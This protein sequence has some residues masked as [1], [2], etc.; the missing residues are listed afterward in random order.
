MK[1]LIGHTGLV[2]SVLA[3]GINTDL[4]YNSAN[5][6]QIEHGK[7]DTVYCAAPSG[8]R[9]LAN[10]D[11]AWDTE[12]IQRLVRSLRT[13]TANRFVLISS[14]DAVYTPESA[15]GSNR[16]A[17][18]HFAQTQFELC[19]VIRLCTLIHPRITKNLLYDIKHYQ[20]LDRVNGAMIRQY[21][22]LS[23][24]C[25]DIGRV[26]QH[27]I[28]TVNLVS[29]PVSDRDIIAQFCPDIVTTDTPVRPYDLH[30]VEPFGKYVI[31]RQRVLEY[32]TEY[33]ND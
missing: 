2:G 8:N 4:S 25:A 16:L 31:S 5:I 24:L 15:Y 32:V 26:I 23:R 18:E 9:L 11:P 28:R 29:E 6:E 12:N 20:Y 19:H 21:Y 3:N 7:F 17:L 22:P 14:V 27:D 33:M 30:S 13:V 10:H 1:T